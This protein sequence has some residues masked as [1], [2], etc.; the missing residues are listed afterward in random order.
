MKEQLCNRM[1][2]FPCYTGSVQLSNPP[3]GILQLK[4][5]TSKLCLKHGVHRKYILYPQC[6]AGSD[7]TLKRTGSSQTSDATYLKTIH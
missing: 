1:Y 5:C 6:A 4:W 7:A 2:L 3:N